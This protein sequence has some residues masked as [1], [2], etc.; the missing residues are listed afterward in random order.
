MNDTT[1]NISATLPKCTAGI[2][3]KTRANFTHYHQQSALINAQFAREI[4]SDKKHQTSNNEI[5]KV[6]YISH[7][8]SSIISS[9]ASLESKINEFIV[10]NL[11]KIDERIEEVDIN[12]LQ[13]FKKIKKK[14]DIIKRLKNVTSTILKHKMLY[15]LEMAGCA[16]GKMEEERLDLLVK[17]RNSLIHF[18][19]EWDNNLNNHKNLQNRTRNHFTLSPFYSSDTIFFPYRC[20][21]A[22]C[23]EWGIKISKAFI[24]TH[25]T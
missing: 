11:E 1:G 22:N 2:S 10:D 6:R 18:T 24:E 25:Y 16:L 8:S 7:I 4:E 20:L 17:I 5:V 13:S 14:E 19:P 23:A 21:S 12:T 3:V 9:C 15:D